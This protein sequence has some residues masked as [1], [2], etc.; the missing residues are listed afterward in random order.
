MIACVLFAASLVQAKSLVLTLADGTRVYYLLGGDTNPMMRLS[1]DGVT[2]NAD[3]YTFGNLK[4][5]YIS[6]TDDPNSIEQQLAEAK[7]SYHDNMLVCTVK[8]TEKAQVWTVAGTRV[9]A[10]IK[11]EGGMTLIDLSSLPQGVYIVV[12]GKAT[13]KVRVE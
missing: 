12:I 7:A 6:S 4:N 8:E 1:D 11:H 13:M 2:V 10:S 3:S 5:F 9:Q